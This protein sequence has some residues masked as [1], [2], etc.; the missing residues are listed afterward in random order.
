MLLLL[1]QR[2]VGGP[3][4]LLLGLAVFLDFSA[5]AQ[6]ALSFE[7]LQKLSPEQTPDPYLRADELRKANKNQEALQAIHGALRQDPDCGKCYAL[8]SGI[9]GNLGLYKEG[10]GDGDLG[11]K[12]SKAP[13][14]KALAAYNKGYNLTNLDKKADALDA[15]QQAVVLDPTYSMA[16]FGRGKIYY[17]L[18]MWKEA[19]AEL[20]QA[21]TLSPK[22]AAAWAYLAESHVKLNDF[23][24]G[25]EAAEKAV[26]FGPT[27]PRSFR[28]RAIGYQVHGRYNEMLADST[29]LVELDP[30]RPLSH[31]LR[32]RA[33]GFLGR[34]DEAL[35]EYAAEPDRKAVE[36]YLN[37]VQKALYGSRLHNCGDNS[38]EIDTPGNFHSRFD[39]CVAQINSALQETAAP[40]NEAPPAK[41]KLPPQIPS[42]HSPKK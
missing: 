14:D 24:L 8:R 39:D 38:T 26:Q 41:R 4:I 2:T 42:K 35:A 27:D 3:S 10:V 25:M 23:A 30:T 15:Y 11:I 29:R 22:L 37:G 16:Y 1:G 12:L 17:F 6:P 5:V 40:S 32:G 19:R 18:G 7:Q 31:L 36:P 20:T 9:L 34:L 21:V 13:R 28:A 33:L